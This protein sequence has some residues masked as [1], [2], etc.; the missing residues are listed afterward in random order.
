MSSGGENE[1]EILLG[2]KQLLAI[3][4]VIAFL[5]FVAFTGGYMVGR[6]SPEKKPLIA[7]APVTDAQPKDSGLETH[8]VGPASGSG[9]EDAGSAAK[10]DNRL[11]AKPNALVVNPDEQEPAPLGAPKRKGKGKAAAKQPSEAAP[12][13]N[14]ADEYTPQSGQL[15]LQVTALA[16]DD[17]YGVADVL[18]KEGFRA[19]SVPKPG[20]SGKVYR[21]LVGPIRDTTELSATRDKLRKVAGFQDVIL[22]RY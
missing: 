10:A 13:S 15:F 4:F 6:G 18:T 16:R 2:N 9:A 17:A 5:L 19:H 14:V 21:V 1:S 7:A 20:S 22:Q 12:A 8:P 11:A 3:F